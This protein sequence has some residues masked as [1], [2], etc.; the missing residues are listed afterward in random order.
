M[1]QQSA[2]TGRSSKINLLPLIYYGTLSRLIGDS[3]RNGLWVRTG[4]LLT[5]F[6]SFFHCVCIRSYILQR[7]RSI[8]EISACHRCSSRLDLFKI[9]FFR[10][11]SSLLGW[12]Y[13][14]VRYLAYYNVV[15][16]SLEIALECNAA[17]RNRDVSAHGNNVRTTHSEHARMRTTW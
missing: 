10:R 17:Y 14:Q 9:S 8:S 12:L 6:L 2:N 3:C 4:R 1:D 5:R 11:R 16:H 7:E 15:C 13:L